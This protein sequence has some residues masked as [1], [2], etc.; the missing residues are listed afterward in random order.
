MA[1]TVYERL[2]DGPSV[3]EEEGTP[4]EPA[5]VEIDAIDL[6]PRKITLYCSCGEKATYNFR[7]AKRVLP[8]CCSS[9]CMRKALPK[10]E[11]WAKAAKSRSWDL[12]TEGDVLEKPEPKPTARQEIQQFQR[13]VGLSDD[14]LLG[15][16]TCQAL[17]DAGRGGMIPIWR[18]R[19][20]EESSGV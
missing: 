8:L 11:E 16:Q 3:V 12:L 18:S 9:A 15:A 20:L 13:E 14:G 6:D 5:R 1:E 10:L 4:P 7:T 19:L 2:L 17:Q